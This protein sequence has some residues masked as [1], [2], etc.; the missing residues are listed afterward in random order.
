MDGSFGGQATTAA[1]RL[2]ISKNLIFAGDDASSTAR[3]SHRES[4]RTFEY[5]IERVLC[6]KSSTQSIAIRIEIAKK[7]SMSRNPPE[8]QTTRRQTV[9]RRGRQQEEKT[10]NTN[11]LNPRWHACERLLLSGPS[12]RG[13]TCS[14]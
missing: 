14:Y 10:T 12:T 8:R 11:D 13:P 4:E 3:R 7:Y 9:M 2:Y 1:Y 6:C 5:E